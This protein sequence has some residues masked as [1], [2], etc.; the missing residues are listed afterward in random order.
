MGFGTSDEGADYWLVKNS[1][2]YDWGD[3]GYIKIARNRESHCGI[4][5]D[6]YYPIVKDY[7]E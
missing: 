1:W 6:S 7:N 5:D 3:K 4:A 2:G